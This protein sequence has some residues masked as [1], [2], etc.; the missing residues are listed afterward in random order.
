MEACRN[1]YRIACTLDLG[2]DYQKDLKYREINLTKQGE[3][4]IE[5][6]SSLMPGLWRGPSRR[7]ELVQQAITQ[8]SFTLGQ[9]VRD[10]GRQGDHRG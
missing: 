2:I 1:A 6:Q 10:S 5:E 8:G 9:R 4:R 3:K 7:T